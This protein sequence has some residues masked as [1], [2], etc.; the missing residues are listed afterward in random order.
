V[1][2]DTPLTFAYGDLGSFSVTLNRA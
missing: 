1:P 2:I